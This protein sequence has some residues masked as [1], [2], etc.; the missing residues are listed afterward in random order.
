MAEILSSLGWPHFTFIFAIVF[1]FIFRTQ[2]SGFIC[3]ISS[4]DKGGVK[5][6][7][8]P[9]AQ[10]EKEK[11]EA[12]QEL[13]L[14]IG[15]SIVLREVEGRIVA[16]LQIKGLETESDTAKVLIKHFAASKIL[17]EFEQIHNLIFGS[18]IYILKK[19]NE[20]KGQ[21]QSNEVV[22]AHFDHVKSL[23]SKEFEDWNFDTYMYFLTSRL[24]VTTESNQYHIT[25]LGV[26]YL[27]WI[28]RNGR[29]ENRP[30]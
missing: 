2:I 21:G 27:T 15:D 22:K 19:L 26:E 11:T 23:F 24:L 1:L 16:D 14:A 18:Q 5:T 29:S 4:I 25:N 30:L 13:L 20:V 6:S 8:V 17:L 12:V 9:E 3:R 10:R 7:P 28:A